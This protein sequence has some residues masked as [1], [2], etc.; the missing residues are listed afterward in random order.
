VVEKACLARRQRVARLRLP[1]FD[2]SSSAMAGSRRPGDDGYVFEVLGGGADHGWAAD[3]DV[4][5][6]MA[7]GTPGWAAV[8]S[9]A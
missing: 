4:F 3:V 7:E 9:K 8:F 5:D 1:W 2:C 6:E